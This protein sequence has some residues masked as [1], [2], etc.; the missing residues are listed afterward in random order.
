M[1]SPTCIARDIRIHS[2]LSVIRKEQLKGSSHPYTLA[3]RLDFRAPSTKIRTTSRCTASRG[4]TRAARRAGMNAAAS[5]TAS[6]RIVMP[7]NVRGPAASLRTADFA[8]PPKRS[9]RRHPPSRRRSTPP[10]GSGKRRAA[11]CHW[12]QR[13]AQ[14]ERRFHSCAASR[15]TPRER[16]PTAARIKATPAKPPRMNAEKRSR[17]NERATISSI[18]SAVETACALS[19][20]RTPCR[21]IA[22]NRRG[23]CGARSS[24]FNMSPGCCAN[25]SYTCGGVG[26]L[27]FSCLTSPTI[28]TI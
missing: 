18:S 25:G 14:C 8:G 4:S 6:S 5:A 26:V 7:A 15:R 19:I 21:T 9:R 3:Q 13:R 16:R 11:Q 23:S 27:R 1:G 2:Q 22:V 12:P 10:A 17:V 28:P 20:A 24:T